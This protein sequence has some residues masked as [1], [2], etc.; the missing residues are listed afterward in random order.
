MVLAQADIDSYRREGVVVLRGV[1]PP[2][3]LSCL[4]DGVAENL[5]HP[6]QWANDY[7]PTGENGRF[8]DDY[9]SWQRI[10]AFRTAAL[11]GILPTIAAELMGTKSPRFFHEHVLVKEPGTATPTPW[12]H[13]DPYYGVDGM[14]NVSLWV[15]LDP[16]PESIAL[17]CLAGSHATGNRY[18]PNRFLDDSP[19]P[20]DPT[21]T[22]ARSFVPLPASIVLDADPGVLVCPARPGDVVAFH[23]RTLHSAPGTIAHPERRRVVS[24]RYVGDDARFATRP[25]TTSP[26]FPS[27][28]LTEGDEL[29]DERFPRII[30]S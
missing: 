5:A 20:V 9:V 21:F 22:N 16:I 26:P 6:S 28:G 4:A 11:E 30:L 17:R 13:D 10:E 1:V 12:H 15:P 3:T 27:H 18:V 14:D 7:T 24:F 25:W 23:F 8:F 2:A 29:D 19:Y